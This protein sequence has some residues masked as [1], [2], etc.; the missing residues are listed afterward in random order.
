ML[1]HR[2]YTI[3]TLL[4][5]IVLSACSSNQQIEVE[6]E[7]VR[8]PLALAHEAAAKGAELY[9]NGM[10]E[11]AVIAFNN[12]IDL[13]E[14][15]APLAS[16]QDSVAY[17]IESMQLNVAKSHVDMAMENI[18]MSLFD[19]AIMHY[20]TA[21]NIYKNHKPVRIS[22]EELDEYVRATYNNLAIAARDAGQYEKA[23]TYY[24]KLLTIEPNNKE[25]LNAKFFIL[26]DYIKDNE[27]AFQVLEDYA[28]VAQEASAYIMLAEGYA[29][30]GNFAKA[31]AA[32]LLA[33]KLRSDADMYTRI[34]NFYRANSQW[35]KANIYLEK[36]VAT[37]PEPSTLAI[38]Y[39]QMGQNYS[40]LGNTAKMI[41]Y[42]EKSVELVPN[43]RLALTLA[44]HYNGAKKWG[45]VIQYSTMVLQE[46]ANNSTAR[47]LRGVAYYQQKNMTAAKADLERLVNDATYGTQA[48]NILKAI[49]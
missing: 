45:K 31:E 21:L 12:A 13:F 15:A 18:E 8:D 19:D 27:R 44:G 17:N 34:G 28:E 24:D 29:E 30:A 47:M 32:Y 2:F 43:S 42:L 10:L 25:V 11:Q 3:V 14:E 20:E 37:N 48:Q 26:K 5:L 6:P 35:G 7:P 40:Q 4:V 33:E 38:V 41:E 9:E 22:Q 49:K 39:A 36:L 16:A 23:L 46:E 1:K